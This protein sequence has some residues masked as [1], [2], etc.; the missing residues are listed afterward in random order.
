VPGTYSKTAEVIGLAKA[1]SAYHGVYAS[2]IRDEGD[3]VTQ[4]IDEAIDIGRQANMPVEISHFKVTYKP[5]WGRSKSTVAQVDQARREG[6]D[7]T[8]DQYPY[9]ASSTTITQVVP[10]WAFAGGKDSLHY[11]LDNADIREKITDEMLRT[12]KNKQLKSY[13]YAVVA[14]YA[15]DTTLNGK[16]IA[17]I[18]ALKGRKARAS[19]EVETILE[20]VANG[21]AQMVFFS[22]DE[23]DLRY[24]MQYPFCMVASDAGIIRYGSG[25]PHPRG[26]GTNARVLGRYVREQKVIRLEEAIRR[27][28]SLPAQK[29]QLRD[30]GLIL[31]G[32]AAD[33]VVFDEEKVIDKSTFSAPHAYSEG[34]RYVFVNGQLAVEEGKQTGIRSG[35]VLHGPGHTAP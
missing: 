35:S 16:N 11:R 33:I 1:A 28:T 12:L 14:R 25:V 32:M 17:E 15:A 31:P 26:Y 7:V 9:I 34:F 22:I 23:E 8:V 19:D 5:N 13:S 4:A 18:N 30:R 29:F 20:M 3:H 24:I 27:M 2:H 10:S 6:I 21:G